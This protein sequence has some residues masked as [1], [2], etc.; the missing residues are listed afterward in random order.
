[1]FTPGPCASSDERDT[2]DTSLEEPHRERDMQDTLAR[3]L[4]TRNPTCPGGTRR[5][6][7]WL[8]AVLASPAALELR[9][10]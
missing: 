1:M 4:E 5:G 6:V 10:R 8:W 3:S 9:R 2:H 7:Q